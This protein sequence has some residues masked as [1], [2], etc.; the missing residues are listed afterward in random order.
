MRQ[1]T[2]EIQHIVDR[3]IAEYHPQRIILFGS[4]A[5]GTPTEDSDIDMLII[6]DSAESPFERRVRV[7]KLAADPGRRVPFSPL[8]LTPVEL[9]QRLLLGDPFYQEIVS[10]GKELYAAN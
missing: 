8:V 4:F 9:D 5:Y 6:R 3:L 7:R 1:A 10:R 2:K